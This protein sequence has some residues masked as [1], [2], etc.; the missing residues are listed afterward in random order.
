[1]ADRQRPGGTPKRRRRVSGHAMLWPE[2]GGHLGS[3][4]NS[5][6]AQAMPRYCTT[7]CALALAGDSSG[8]SETAKLNR[9]V[10]VRVGRSAR[11][12]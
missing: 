2:S 9:Q 8:M 1:M 7:H 11:M 10:Q 3:S 6:R 5:M 4:S 12:G